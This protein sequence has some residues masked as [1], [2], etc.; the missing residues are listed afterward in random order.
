MS[1][2]G[3]HSAGFGLAAKEA[4]EAVGGVYSLRDEAGNV[5]RT[6]RTKDL[7][8]RR[9]E[10]ARDPELGQY[11][12]RPEYRTD[13]Y[14]TQR[15]LEQLLHDEWLPPLNRIRPIS[16]RNRRIDEYLRAG[17]EFGGGR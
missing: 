8:R 2:L 14:T 11:R 1:R 15:G 13:D 5:V 4:D 12:F 9:G 7:A 3:A 6:G 16:P 10:H 17:Q